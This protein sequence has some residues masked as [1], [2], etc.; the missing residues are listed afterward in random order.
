MRGFWPDSLRGQLLLLTLVCLVL[1]QVVN[2]STILLQ[3]RHQRELRAAWLARQTAE[4]YM[5]IK[6]GDAAEQA[7]MLDMLERLYRRA[8][9]EIR[10]S[11]EEEKPR[12]LFE[13]P[14]NTLEVAEEA[15]S[16][17]LQVSGE[18]VL[19]EMYA[20][21]AEDEG[22][23]TPLLA[24]RL[25]N[26]TW[27]CV[28]QLRTVHDS[29][30]WLYCGAIVLEF[31][32]FSGLILFLLHRST[33]RLE[34]LRRLAEQ[35]GQSPE[36]ADSIPEDG[37]REIRETSRS[38]N[39]MRERVMNSM[40]ERDR[41]LA[42][43]RHD[44]RT[45]LTRLKLWAEEAEPENVRLRLLENVRQIQDMAAQGIELAESLSPREPWAMLDLRAFVETVSDDY[46]E[47]GRNVT[48]KGDDRRMQSQPLTIR[49]RPLCLRRCLSN[50][51]EN[52]LK[53]AGEA[54][55]ALVSDERGVCIEVC[56]HGPGIQPE[57]LEKVFEPWFRV[58]S[59]RN[60]RTGG[61]GL[62]LTI[63]RNMAGF[64]GASLSLCNRPEGGL[65]AS[66]CF[67]R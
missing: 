63:A 7:R 47:E 5:L 28:A 61:S 31:I 30:D 40:E 62:G 39:R 46:A 26:G 6:S 18:K 67:K 44:L 52:A 60:R 2:G 64:S 55:V 42:A 41:M 8:E 11:F 4:W 56:D 27:F 23:P 51:I 9:W 29:H 58:E 10:F 13:R 35:F 50:L 65:R 20:C 57:L 59:S 49:T 36:S 14:R 22:R 43:L 38:L 17:A 53:Y 24:V 25:D 12:N 33:L 21:Y 48:L 32:I 54:E 15:F 37:C 1:F 3:Q 34:R 45:P 16:K 66:I 19:P